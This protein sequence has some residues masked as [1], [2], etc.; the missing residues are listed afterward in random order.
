MFASLAPRIRALA[1][2]VVV[3]SIAACGNGT[4][5]PTRANLVATAE[6][7]GQ[8]NTLLAALQAAGLQQELQQG[9]PYTVFAPTDAAFAALPPGTVEALLQD[10]QALRSVLLFH[11]VPGRVTAAQAATLDAAPT[12]NGASVPMMPSGNTLRVGGATVVQAD[13]E[14]SNGI[15]HVIDAVLIP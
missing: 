8:F 10:R 5:E 11:V 1:L 7:A 6:A 12:L 15:I 14:A 2:G 4:T 9:G 13:V 3:T